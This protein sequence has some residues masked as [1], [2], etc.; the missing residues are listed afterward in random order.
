MSQSH[1]AEFRAG[2]ILFET[3]E[4]LATALFILEGRVAFELTLN[5]RTVRLEIG[6]NQFI[7]D[8]AVAVADKSTAEDVRYH[9]R[10]VAIEPVRAAR[11]PVEDIRAELASCPPM[12]RAWF[13]SF[14][15]RVLL[16]IEELSAPE[17]VA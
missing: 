12:I 4:P 5:D 14:V 3:T 11:I 7:G 9:A 10:A 15:S 8:A 17:P 6:P 13:A 2:E 1:D 16:V